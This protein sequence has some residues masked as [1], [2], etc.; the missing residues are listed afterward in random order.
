MPTYA[1]QCSAC[2]KPGIVY[3]KV[4][5]RDRLPACECGGTLFRP[6][7]APSVWGNVATFTPY[8]SPTH[9]GKWI[10]SREAAQA[11]LKASGC[12][13]MEAGVKEQIQKNRERVRSELPPAVDK[14]VDNIVRD[15][16]VCGRL[17]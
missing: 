4:E 16:N 9:P 14:A 17:E 1:T 13:R 10:T 15:L 12:F 7:Q 3:R 11:D 6:I 5:E 2:G 8:E